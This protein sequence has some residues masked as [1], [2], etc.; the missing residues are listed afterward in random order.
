MDLESEVDHENCSTCSEGEARSE[1]ESPTTSDEEFI[2]SDA[3]MEEED[4]LEELIEE[5]EKLRKEMPTFKIV[6]SKKVQNCWPTEPL[7][8]SSSF[9]F[10]TTFS[11][12]EVFARF[13]FVILAWGY[14]PCLPVDICQPSFEVVRHCKLY[15][16][17]GHH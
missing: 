1:D 15:S 11:L 9:H 16:V 5:N 17:A 12:R 13:F 2:V 3:E 14:S 7:S 6:D 10:S 4:E 8:G